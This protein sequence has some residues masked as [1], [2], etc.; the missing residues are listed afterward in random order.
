MSQDAKTEAA[1]RRR[2]RPVR[3]REKNSEYL[4]LPVETLEGEELFQGSDEEEIARLWEDVKSEPPKTRRV[5]VSDFDKLRE[6]ERLNK[7][8]I[9]LPNGSKVACADAEEYEEVKNIAAPYLAATEDITQDGWN[10]VYQLLTLHLL[11]FVINR[12][13]TEI[14]KRAN[15]IKDQRKRAEYEDSQGGLQS[16]LIKQVNQVQRLITEQRLKLDQV[17]AA[18]SKIQGGTL[19]EY[20]QK[21]E[22]D[23]FEHCTSHKGEYQW[24]TCCPEPSCRRYTEPFVVLQQ[25]PHFAFDF[26]ASPSLI[27]NERVALL[28]AKY[29]TPKKDWSDAMRKLDSNGLSFRDAAGILNISPIGWM[30]A[31][32]ERCQDG[33]F[34]F[35]M[36]LESIL[37]KPSALAKYDEER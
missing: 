35:P 23:T 20:I 22:Q 17:R 25:A 15:A 29:Y 27:W 34:E 2:R 14:R 24:I 11:N 16:D 6:M 10:D 26:A 33:N 7:Y 5:A 9:E 19:V 37:N 8:Y 30:A 13:L 32:Y 28:T 21:I 36:D 1:P 3:N 12:K 31:I 4:N 18:A